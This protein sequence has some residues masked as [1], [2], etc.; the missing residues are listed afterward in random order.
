MPTRIEPL[1]QQEQDV[2][3]MLVAG[4]DTGAIARELGVEEET[5]R[6]LIKA[7]LT[8]LGAHTRFDA[9]VIAMRNGLI[10]ADPVD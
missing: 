8:K 2:L 10:R 4:L 9:L 7:L 3:R 5:A 1:P 6:Q